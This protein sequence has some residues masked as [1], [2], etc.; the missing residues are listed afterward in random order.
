MTSSNSSTGSGWK[1]MISTGFWVGNQVRIIAVLTVVGVVI[2]LTLF[3]QNSA[4]TTESA[5]WADLQEGGVFGTLK[6]EIDLSGPVQGTKAEPWAIYLNSRNAFRDKRLEEAARL[7]QKLQSE[8]PDFPLVASGKI[9]QL[10]DAIAKERSWNESSALPDENPKPSPDHFVTLE[11]ELG[12]VKIGLYVDQAPEACKAFLALVRDESLIA[13]GFDEAEEDSYVILSPPRPEKATEDDESDDPEHDHEE[14]G[15]SNASEDEDE[16]PEPSDLAKG[17][18]PDRNQLSHFAGAL[19]FFRAWETDLTPDSPP[20]IAIYVEDTAYKDDQEVVFGTVLEGVDL[21]KQVSTRPKVDD[22]S[23]L[24]E[25]LK[26]IRIE[27][28]AGAQRLK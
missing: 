22:D 17:V 20:R 23:M 26:V 18:V 13:G 25:P 7:A 19:S 1:A 12:S 6:S 15:D 9:S 14:D 2:G 27:E 4:R 5:G 10:A 11:T 3:L 28:S 24:V 21:L 8:H 16:E